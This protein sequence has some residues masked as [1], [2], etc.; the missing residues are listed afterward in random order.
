MWS[1][2]SKITCPCMQ[3]CV[4]K[5]DA[6]GKRFSKKAPKNSRRVYN[7]EH[8]LTRINMHTKNRHKQAHGCSKQAHGCVTFTRHAHPQMKCRIQ[9]TRCRSYRRTHLAGEMYTPSEHTSLCKT[10]TSPGLRVLAKY[11]HPRLII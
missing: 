10:R 3:V 9:T 5:W 1:G 2:F 11:F 7:L 6:H 8:T 4:C